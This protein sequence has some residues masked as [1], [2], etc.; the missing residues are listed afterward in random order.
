MSKKGAIIFA[1]RNLGS[2]EINPAQIK[3]K[4]AIGLSPKISFPK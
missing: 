3:S 4:E 2:F 1:T